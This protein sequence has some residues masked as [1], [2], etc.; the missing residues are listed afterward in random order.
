MGSY[1]QLIKL[2]HKLFYS[3]LSL[4]KLILQ[5]MRLLKGKGK[6]KEKGGVGKEIDL[7]LIVI[8]GNHKSTGAVQ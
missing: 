2:S 7:L 3:P 1:R 5:N 4:F 6:E 8:K